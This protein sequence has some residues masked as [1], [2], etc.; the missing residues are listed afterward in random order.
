ML[1]QHF[2]HSS[3]TSA[4]PPCRCAATP[5]APSCRHHR[6]SQ[7]LRAQTASLRP[8]RVAWVLAQ[9]RGRARR[10]DSGLPRMAALPHSRPWARRHDAC[11]S[12]SRFPIAPQ[13][14]STCLMVGHVVNGRETARSVP[15][16]RRPAQRRGAT[17]AQQAA[18]ALVR[19]SVP[20]SRLPLLALPG[21]WTP[22]SATVV[23]CFASGAPRCLSALHSRVYSCT[24]YRYSSCFT[25]RVQVYT[26]INKYR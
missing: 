19:F 13:Y 5:V 2:R 22:L 20:T 12:K 21:P 4:S 8:L 17:S 18:R 16:K 7:R 11:R 14:H 10:L 1:A 25:P 15:S 26:C 24:Q 9:R 3:P 23:C 6:R